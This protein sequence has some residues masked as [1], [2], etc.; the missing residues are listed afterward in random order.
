MSA[1]K[2][3]GSAHS[4]KQSAASKGGTK[5]SG[6]AKSGAE[7]SNATAERSPFFDARLKRELGGVLVAILAVALFIAVVAPGTAILSNVISDLFRL[8]IGI[9]AYILPFL[10]FIWAASFFIEKEITDGALRLGFGLAV[11]FVSVLAISGVMVPGVAGAQGN[12]DLIFVDKTLMAHGGY[13]GG[14]IAW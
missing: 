4:K 9:G 6:T 1:Q 7:K 14:S 5:K 3:A 8:V 2:A 11:I 10:M 13:I 12:P